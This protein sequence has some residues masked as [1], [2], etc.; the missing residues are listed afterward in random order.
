MQFLLVEDEPKIAASI[1]EALRE[2]G[3]TTT[4]AQDLPEAL[5]AVRA[6]PFDLVILDLNLP[7]GSGLDV[8]RSLRAGGDRAP[9][10]IL[11]A[12]DSEEDRVRG[13]DAGADDYLGKPFSMA[14][15]MARV[16]AL[17]RRGSSPAALA[18]LA[19]AGVELDLRQR[20]AL[21]DGKALDLTQKEFDLLQLLL[22]NAGFTVSREQIAESIWRGVPRA[23]PLDNVIEVHIAR[24]RRKVDDGY[25]TKLIRTIR[26][27]GFMLGGKP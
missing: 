4:V 15:L 2:R 11:T 14:E 7:G 22:E 12:R 17:L 24:L 21:R 9:V 8:L 19:H 1:R 20:R 10:L 23:T 16:R 13:L 5:E 6:R 26:G 27:V 25:D 3:Y 18:P